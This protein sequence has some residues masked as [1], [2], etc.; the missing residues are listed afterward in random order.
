[1]GKIGSEDCR[2][3]WIGVQKEL[4]MAHQIDFERFASPSQKAVTIEYFIY[5]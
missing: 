2:H 1:M 3:D 5:F 4:I